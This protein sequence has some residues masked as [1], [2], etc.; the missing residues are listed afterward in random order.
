MRNGTYS[1]LDVACTI[2]GP[3]GGPFAL[4]GEGIADEGVTIAM[5]EEK[6]TLT[7]GA[8][9][10]WMHSLHAA[11]AGTITV[12]LMKTSPANKQLNEMMSAN[13]GLNTLSISNHVTG[14]VVVAEGAGFTKKPDLTNAKDGGN[15]EWVFNCGRITTR[16]GDGTNV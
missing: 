16:L 10:G 9:G 15:N 13:Y 7:T 1:F 3:G 14:D 6:G 2:T 12:R 11:N 4:D 5:R 8:D